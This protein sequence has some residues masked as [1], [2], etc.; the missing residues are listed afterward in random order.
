MTKKKKRKQEQN[1]KTP[2]LILTIIGLFIVGFYLEITKEQETTHI[3]M[4]EKSIGIGKID[5]TITELENE[6]LTQII[7]PQENETIQL[8]AQKIIKEINGKKIQMYGYNGQIPG[9]LF[10]VKQGQ[11]ITINFTNNLDHPTTI[12]SHGI[13]INNSFDGVPHVTQEPIK[14]GESFIYKINFD[15]SGIYWY[16]P[17]IREDLQQELGLYGNYLVEP[18]EKNYYNQ[19]ERVVKIVQLSCP[20]LV[21]VLLLQK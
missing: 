8:T 17:H 20:V 21:A 7:I 1:Y 18:L 10:I 9:P 13:R 4:I 3:D 15:D 2:I 12:H 5:R 16:H 14:P 11:T 6:Q 19:Q